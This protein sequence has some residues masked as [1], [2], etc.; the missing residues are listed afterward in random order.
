V[1]DSECCV[2]EKWQDLGLLP[3]HS[4]RSENLWHQQNFSAETWIDMKYLG[5]DHLFANS[6]ERV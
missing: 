1:Q 6:A 4:L 2:L 3:E 5:I